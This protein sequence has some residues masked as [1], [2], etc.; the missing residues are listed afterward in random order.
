MLSLVFVNALHLHVEEGFRGDDGAG[1][2]GNERGKTLFVSELGGAPLLLKLWIIGKRFELAKLVQVAQPAVADTFGNDLGKAGIADGHEAARCHAVC[3]VAK[4]LRPELGEIA[5]DC[6]P[7]QV[8]VQLRDAVDGVA[9]EASEMR[10]AH[11]SGSAFV[12]ERKPRNA[13]LVAWI[14]RAHFIEETTIELKDDFEMPREQCAEKIDCPLL[15]RLGQECVISIG[16][17]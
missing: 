11:I 7:E 12:N 5:Q 14:G 3:H 9:A 13:G 6:L 8:G 2:F 17:G 15:Q 4:F 10:H 16:E 1:A